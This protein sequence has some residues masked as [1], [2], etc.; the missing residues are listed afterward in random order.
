MISAMTNH[1]PHEQCIMQCGSV[2]T[3]H[4][5]NTITSFRTQVLVLNALLMAYEHHH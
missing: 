4:C 1:S 3:E 2:P 5:S